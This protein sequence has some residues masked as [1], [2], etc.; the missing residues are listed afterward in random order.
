[1]PRGIPVAT[2]AI[3]NSTNAAL[4]AIRI[5]G[6]YDSKWLTEMNQYMLNMETEVLGKAETLEEIGYEDYLTDKLKK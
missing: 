2:V 3:N 5:L 1:M 6:A 4:L